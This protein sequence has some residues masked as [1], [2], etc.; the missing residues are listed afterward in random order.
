M[1]NKCRKNLNKSFY[2]GKAEIFQL[3][4]LTGQKFKDVGIDSFQY[5]NQ[6]YLHKALFKMTMH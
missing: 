2:D 1:R 4:L 6:Y 3:P 5:K